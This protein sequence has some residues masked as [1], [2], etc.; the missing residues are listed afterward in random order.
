MP[1]RLKLAKAVYEILEMDDDFWCHFYRLQG[2]WLDLEGEAQE[3]Y[4]ARKRALDLAQKLS[5]KENYQE[6][7]KIYLLI[8]GS[9]HFFM[10]EEITALNI[11]KESKKL[12]YR[13]EEMNRDQVGDFN[14]YL[15]GII[16]DFIEAIE[17]S[18]SPERYCPS[19]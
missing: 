1:V 10:K 9:M 15:D 2:Y 18:K 3:A 16:N 13:T 5:N 11:F 12:K 17:R 14:N 19:Q 7:R 6:I 4:E 8:G